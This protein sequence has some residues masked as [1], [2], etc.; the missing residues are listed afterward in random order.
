MQGDNWIDKVMKELL[1]AYFYHLVSRLKRMGYNIKESCF[2]YE[3]VYIMFDRV[4]NFSDIPQG[5]EIVD[6]IVFDCDNCIHT[7]SVIC[8]MC[9]EYEETVSILVY[10]EFEPNLSVVQLYEILMELQAWI[11]RMEAAEAG[12]QNTTQTDM[13]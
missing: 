3:R 7:N 12:V 11:D 4:H 8:K 9:R 6:T 2:D 5:F 13:C 1:K 10:S